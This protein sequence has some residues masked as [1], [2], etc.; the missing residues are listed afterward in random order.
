MK[1]ILIINQHGENRGD[2]A[3]MRAM[4]ARFKEELGDVR[5]TLL[6]QFKDR[7]L[8]LNF[9]EQV[10]D[11]PIA[12]PPLDYLRALIYSAT[13]LA[14]IDL[15]SMLSGA[16]RPIIDAYRSA[17]LVV[18]APGGPY[19]GDIYMDHEIVHWWYVWLASRFG[20]PLFLYAPS[21]GPFESKVMNP[22]RRRLYR[23]FDVL[24]TREEVS[25]QYLHGLLGARTKVHV[26]ADSAIQ[27]SFEPLDRHSHFH[28]DRAALAGRFLVA[29]SLNNYRY[30]GASNPGQLRE[31]YNRSMLGLIEH[32]AR[33][34]DCHF[35]LVP[36]LY[37]NAHDD[38]TYLREIGAQLSTAVSFEVVAPE[39]DSDTQRRLFAMADLHVASRYHPAIFGHTGYTPGICIYYEHKALGFMTQ[40]GLERFAFDIREPRLDRLCQA[41]DELLEQRE[42]IVDHLEQC[43]PELRTRARRTTDLAVEL[44]RSREASRG[45]AS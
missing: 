17:D 29:I 19:F 31:E 35:L 36:Q 1:H 25:Q 23:K 20:K 32:L 39:T 4:L 3:A 2:E 42:Q 45:A 11:L 15:E 5:F 43:V 7:A 8:R 13:N 10:E 27:Q 33:R 34:R 26:T 12:L 40:L 41:A 38:V 28:G 22:I 37:G 24:V 9:R 16:M 44:L 21:A 30:P 18:S 14:R 6:Y